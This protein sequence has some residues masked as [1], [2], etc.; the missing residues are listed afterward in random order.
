MGYRFPE[1]IFDAAA[2]CRDAWSGG[3][4]W[5]CGGRRAVAECG[6]THERGY[7]TPCGEHAGAYLGV[8]DATVVRFSG[9]RA[10]WLDLRES[11]PVDGC[12]EVRRASNI[13]PQKPMLRAAF[14]ILRA[15]FG[16]DG[17]VAAW[18]RGWRCV[19]EVWIVDGPVIGPYRS[20]ESAVFGERWWLRVNRGL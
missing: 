19:W 7:T 15:V 11:P 17:R 3:V 13:F 18:T 20:H 10:E 5:E 2:R 14:R 12:A 8:L 16:D 4:H 9:G 1:T 6:C